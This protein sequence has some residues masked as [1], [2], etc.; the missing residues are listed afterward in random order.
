LRVQPFEALIR[1]FRFCGPARHHS[2]A[3]LFVRSA[4]RTG[5]VD[6]SSPPYRSFRHMVAS[7]LSTDKQ[8]ASLWSL[9]GLTIRQLARGVWGGINQTDLLNRAYELAYNFLL[10]LFPFLLFLVALFGTLVSQKSPFRNVLLNYIQPAL[11]PAAY[12]LLAGTFQEITHNTAGGKIT[13]GLLFLLFSGSGGITQLISTLNAAY[14]VHEGRSWIKVHLISIGLTLA[15]SVLIIVAALLALV[16]DHF[17]WSLGQAVGLDLAAAVSI[18]ILH[19][20]IA[21]GSVILAFAIVYYLAPDVK[22]KHWYWI[23]PGSVV[24]VALWVIASVGLRVY[25]H[26][27]NSY[28]RIYGSLGAVIILLLWFYVTGLAILI[29]GEVNATI[30]HAAAEQGHPE[31]KPAGRKAA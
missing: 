29:G 11:P 21:V 5:N 22:E 17:L 25:L 19:W 6:E 15:I 30:E 16:E 24:G 3:N 23:T 8:F 20:I 4:H 26:F 18:R 1:V 27:F 31:A 12:H 9:G 2:I 13:F 10:A 7:L 28:T 14:E